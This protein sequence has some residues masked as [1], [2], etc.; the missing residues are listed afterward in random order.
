MHAMIMTLIILKP[1]IGN[2]NRANFT[3]FLLIVICFCMHVQT[4]FIKE[5]RS[6][7]TMFII[8][9]DSKKNTVPYL[10]VEL[11]LFWT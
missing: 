7:N 5:I 3:L 2:S 6:G 1:F 8:R 10:F 4:N 9:V 11:F